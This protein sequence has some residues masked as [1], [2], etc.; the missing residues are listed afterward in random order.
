[1]TTTAGDPVLE[2][3]YPRAFAYAIAPNIA[4][5]VKQFR[6]LHLSGAMV[7][8]DQKKSLW[9]KADVRKIKVCQCVH[10]RDQS[11]QRML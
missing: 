10:A 8:R 1:M 9:M 6:Y 3:Q 11:Q 7:E 4:S 2:L 5:G